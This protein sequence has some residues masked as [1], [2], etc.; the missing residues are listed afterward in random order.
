MRT[1]RSQGPPLRPALSAR[2]SQAPAS[3]Q[4]SWQPRSPRLLSTPYL[5]RRG[6]SVSRAGPLTGVLCPPNPNQAE[7]KF[8]AR[9]ACVPSLRFTTSPSLLPI[10]SLRREEGPSELGLQ[11]RGPQQT[12]RVG[13]ARNPMRTPQPSVSA[14]GGGNQRKPQCSPVITP[15]SS[16]VSYQSRAP[17]CPAS[18]PPGPA[19]GSAPLL[20]SDEVQNTHRVLGTLSAWPSCAPHIRGRHALLLT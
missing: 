7:S 9:A 8:E 1:D 13:E 5:L 16:P 10:W 20:S 15:A 18:P 12:L 4:P 6:P 11:G 19:I 2:G 3:P 14:M 17:W